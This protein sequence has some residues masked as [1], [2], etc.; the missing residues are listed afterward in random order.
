M[1]GATFALTKREILR[2]VRQRSRWVGALAT[3]L[4]FWFLIGGGLGDSFRDSSGA[5]EGG[6]LAFFYPGAILLSVLFTA[7][8][9]TI[10][11]IEDRHQGFLQGVLVSPVQRSALVLAKVLGGALLGLLQ[12][13]LL[14]AFA[15]L[16]G[17]Q[18]NL[19]SFLGV[20]LLL[21]LIAAALTAMG[22]V[23]AWII[24]STQGYHGIM[25]VVFVPMW[26]LSGAVFPPKEG[27][28][29]GWV[30]VVNPLS[31]GVKAIRQLF[32]GDLVTRDYLN[33]LAVTGAFFIV[34]FALSVRLVK[35]NSTK[36]V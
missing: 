27:T 24:D 19:P 30:T 34:L 9:S 36:R 7:I 26:I 33:A 11:V 6:Y 22:F 29:L 31:Y 25:N 35:E 10:S 32:A 3:P 1:L 8:F 4:L 15:P 14:L 5:S 13:M 16:A 20:V 18:L 21:F 17:A 12:G 28:F 2:F 23:F